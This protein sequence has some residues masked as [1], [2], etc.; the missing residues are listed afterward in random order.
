LNINDE[1]ISLGFYL[2]AKFSSTQAYSAVILHA[3]EIFPT[4]LRSFGYG[5]C[6]FSGKLTSVLSPFISLYLVSMT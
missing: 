5:I 2:L 3:P 4:N 6:L 1:R